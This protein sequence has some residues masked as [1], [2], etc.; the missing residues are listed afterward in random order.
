MPNLAK[1][2]TCVQSVFTLKKLH[3]LKS[4]EE[5]GLK[6]FQIKVVCAIISEKEGLIAP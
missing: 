4:F 3:A 1:L 2:K 6:T 5:N